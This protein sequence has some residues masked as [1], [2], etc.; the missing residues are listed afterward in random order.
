[1]LVGRYHQ[2]TTSLPN[3]QLRN[4]ADNKIS[5]EFSSLPNRQLRKRSALTEDNESTSLPNRQLRKLNSKVCS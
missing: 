1:M 3:R 4:K 2:V 5:A